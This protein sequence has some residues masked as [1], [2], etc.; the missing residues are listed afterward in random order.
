MRWAPNPFQEERYFCLLRCN[1]KAKFGRAGMPA[2]FAAATRLP[3]S[4]R[5][6]LRPL[7]EA[8]GRDVGP[9]GSL[10]A[11]RGLVFVNIAGEPTDQPQILVVR[12][13]RAREPRSDSRN[14]RGQQ[15]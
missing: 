12:T 5:L 10:A 3:A 7:P 15:N 8:P 14:Q 9:A 11:F 13:L 1:A 6:P 2:V 4:V